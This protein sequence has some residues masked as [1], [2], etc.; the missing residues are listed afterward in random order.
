[1][2]YQKLQPGLAAKVVLSDTIDIPLPSSP[3]LTG[4]TTGTS[5][6]ELVN[7]A[8]GFTDIPELKA[9]AIVVNTNTST[10]AT[11]VSI[12]S[13]TTLTLSAD[14]FVGVAPE[15]YEIYLDP[16]ANHSEGCIIYISGDG[17]VK[18]KTVSGSEVTYIGLKGGTFLPI[19][20]IRVF[21][22]GTTV[23]TA[24]IANW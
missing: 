15:N 10:I 22:T 11:V 5:A 23:A 13:A 16:K 24:L 18:V 12:D 21:D 8:G 17:N 4:A 1:M 19:Q 9:G 7:A 2:A 3:K 6:N 14:I 20:V